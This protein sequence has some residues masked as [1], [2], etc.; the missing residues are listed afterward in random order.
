MRAFVVR[1]TQLT[2]QSS[3]QCLEQKPCLVFGEWETLKMVTISSFI[4]LCITML[5]VTDAQGDIVWTSQE[6]RRV[7]VNNPRLMFFLC[8][9][10]YIPAFLTV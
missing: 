10:V 9:V 7:R 1:V 4:F 6:C 8:C 2:Q 3:T 5:E